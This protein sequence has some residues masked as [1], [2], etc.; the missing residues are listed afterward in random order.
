MIRQSARLRLAFVLAAAIATTALQSGAAV[1]SG[2]ESAVTP[3]TVKPSAVTAPTAP[4][5]KPK[6]RDTYPFRGVIGSVDAQARTLTLVGKQTR[7][8]IHVTDTTRLEKSGKVAVFDDLKTGERIG[9]T[10]KKNPM[11]AEEALLIR[12]GIKAGSDAPE[13]AD[14]PSHAKEDESEKG[15]KP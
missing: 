6:K 4:D 1:E 10:L 8:T 11:G 13:D 15:G 5:G 9:G 3:T 7:R 14:M 2:P 12:V